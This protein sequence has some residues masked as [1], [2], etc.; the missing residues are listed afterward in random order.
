MKYALLKM[1]PRVLIWTKAIKLS[2]RAG[3]KSLTAVIVEQNSPTPNM[4]LFGQTHQRG[5][6]LHSILQRR[7]LF[8]KS[9]SRGLLRFPDGRHYIIWGTD[10]QTSSCRSAAL[11]GLPITDAWVISKGA[12]WNNAKHEKLS[13]ALWS[14]LDTEA[15]MHVGV[16]LSLFF[17][18][19]GWDTGSRGW[20]WHR[21]S[22]V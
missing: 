8:F 15:L 7:A 19:A 20:L 13:P 18:F 5:R 12:L 14:A 17:G 4:K 11:W 21:V 6:R 22:F 10:S 2:L 9:L 3:Q 16:N 1:V